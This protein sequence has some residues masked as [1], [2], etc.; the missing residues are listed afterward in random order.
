MS[1]ASLLGRHFP[2]LPLEPQ[3]LRP[4]ERT[5]KDQVMLQH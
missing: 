1:L 5:V 3:M 2:F 4:R